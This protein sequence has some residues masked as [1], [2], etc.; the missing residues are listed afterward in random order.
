MTDIKIENMDHEF[1][2]HKDLDVQETEEWLE[3]G[4]RC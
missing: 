3:A 1:R 2:M 4:K